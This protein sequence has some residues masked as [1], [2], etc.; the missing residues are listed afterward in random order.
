MNNMMGHV[1]HVIGPYARV[2][3]GS[4]LIVGAPYVLQPLQSFIHEMGH[5]QAYR[6]IYSN[7]VPSITVSLSGIGSCMRGLLPS[8]SDSI[9]TK[10]GA[11]L[12]ESGRR[13]FVSSSGPLTQII[14]SCA[15]M[16][17]YPR[18]ASA[19]VLQD[20]IDIAIYARSAFFEC[21]P[22]HDYCTVWKHGGPFAYAALASAAAVPVGLSL[23]NLASALFS[24]TKTVIRYFQKVVQGKQP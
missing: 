10:F 7:C 17:L 15:A 2:V 3:A 4:A 18:A 5:A 19:L 21:T 1:Q 6:V 22:T 16:H 20:A 11:L 24:E 8:H 12:G 14:A 9:F 23:Y 13:V